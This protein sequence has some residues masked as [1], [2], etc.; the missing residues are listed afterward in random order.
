ME[1]QQCKLRDNEMN[2][3]F[4]PEIST[5]NIKMN[6]NIDHFWMVNRGLIYGSPE[7]KAFN[8]AIR[9]KVS[10]SNKVTTAEHDVQFL[11]DNVAKVEAK[12][13]VEEKER[14]END[15]EVV[16][17]LKKQYL[18]NQ[19]ELERLARQQEEILRL[20]DFREKSEKKSGRNYSL[21]F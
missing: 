8:Y 3:L 5:L 2:F 18:K 11:S 16:V 12:E 10:S 9:N 13:R 21:M 1:E 14:E 20:I 15:H 4:W 7:E 6:L 19:E 17:L